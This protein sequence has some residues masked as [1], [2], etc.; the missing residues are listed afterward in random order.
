[1]MHILT[2]DTS[3]EQCSCALLCGTDIQAR[4]EWAPRR[5]AELLL[6][7]AEALLAEA[8]LTP[9]QLDAV[10]FG[11]GPGSFTGLRIACG[12]A[13]GVALA[14]DI[15]ALPISSLAALAQAAVQE[16]DGEQVLAALDARMAE[17]YWG[18]F[19]RNAQGIVEVQDEE[20]LSLPEAVDLAAFSSSQWLAVGT[21][22]AA[23]PAL[24]KRVQQA[25]GQV[26]VLRYS[27]AEAL[28]PLATTALQQGLGVTAAQ[29][30]PVYLRN[31]V[32]HR[33]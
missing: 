30:L 21:A 13:Q 22:W 6:P 27:Q 9:R 12:V 11:R 32:T 19:T 7:M 31:Q 23:Y 1:M 2:L 28:L 15:P 20:H 14:A 26:P 24:A 3:T 16:F 29:A 4:S 33:I 10:A 25:S 8:G 5:H 18:R 17:V